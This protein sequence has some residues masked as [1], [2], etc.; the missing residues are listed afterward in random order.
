MAHSEL[1]P[2]PGINPQAI[3]TE[4]LLAAGMDAKEA[5]TIC[6]SIPSTVGNPNDGG[7]GDPIV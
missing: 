6:M 2:G 3:C 5:Q 4:A 7:K 1:H